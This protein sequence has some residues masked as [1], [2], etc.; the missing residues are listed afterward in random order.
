MLINLDIDLTMLT[1][2]KIQEGTN[3]HK[4]IKLTVGTMRQPDKYG[5]DLTVWVAQTKDE[6]AA[7]ADRLYVGKGKTFGNKQEQPSIPIVNGGLKGD[8]PF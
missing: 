7:K 8:L 1:K 5:N 2:D 3:G 6:R 4:Y